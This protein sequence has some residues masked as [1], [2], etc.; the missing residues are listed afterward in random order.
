MFGSKIK[1]IVLALSVTIMAGSLL[2]FPKESVQASTRGL[3]MW[4]EIVF[5][6]LLPFFIFSELMIGFGV[7]RFI[8]VLLE[9]LMRPLF[10]VPGVGGFVW[11][12][13][14][15]SGYPT[16]AKLTARLRQE[17]QLTK[18]E[19]E[20]LV[21]FTN[22]SNPLFIFA[23]VSYSFFQNITLGIILAASHYLGNF[24]VGLIMR[25]YKHGE[26]Q[27][28]RKER[29]FN[30]M[31]SSMRTAF[32]AMHETRIKDQRPLGKILGDAV[33]SS[34]QTLLM[35]GGFIILFSVINKLLYQMYITGLLAS[36]L[37]IT[38]GILHFPSEL[39]TPLIAGLIEIT[40]GSQMTSQ[41]Q[42]VPLMHQ[43]IITSFILAFCGFSVQAQVASIL[44]QTDINFKP[45]FFARII[46]AFIASLYVF[47]FWKPFYVYFYKSTP[48]SLTIPA[49]SNY[50]EGHLTELYRT[51]LEF[52]PIL[53]ITSLFVYILIYMNRL[54][55][56][57]WY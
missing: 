39:S 14:M 9:P 15:A 34:I 20:R 37:E 24:T 43:T 18:T 46:H 47:I 27:G 6:S 40:L 56:S 45:F 17:G 42:N 32:S 26:D 30:K 44:S 1:T 21:S 2:S 3:H 29:G 31:K 8:G 28:I 7:V 49:T 12:M 36:F 33:T 38:L 55:Q 11:A 25:F 41:L 13:G 5:P 54:K 53:T 35:I 16:G 23:V 52:G 22:S 48:S 50:Q 10:R 19:A 51:M 57:K 4:W